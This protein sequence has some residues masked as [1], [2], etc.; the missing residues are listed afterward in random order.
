MAE[1]GNDLLDL[2][3]DGEEVKTTQI[4]APP[5]SFMPAVNA[6]S[7]KMIPFWRSN[8]QAWFLQLESQFD[9][10]GINQEQTKFNHLLGA[11]DESVFGELSDLIA[12]PPRENKFTVFKEALIS[13]LSKSDNHKIKQLLNELVLGDSRPSHLLR[14]MRTL[15]AG[16][17]SDEI[18]KSLWLQRLP[19]HIQGILACSSGSV[20]ELSVMADKIIEVSGKRE[21]YSVSAK[22]EGNAVGQL[23]K[24]IEEL[25]YQVKMLTNSRSRT[26]E[27][28]DGKRRKDLRR[29][30]SRHRESSRGHELCWYHFKFGVNASKCIQPCKFKQ[31]Q[32][33]NVVA[34]ATN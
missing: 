17:F 18:L 29:S 3:N 24:Q 23:Q 20:D 31:T 13:R 28:Y 7:V 14:E 16:K 19:S 21:V 25:T 30:K 22:P 32:G 6:V 15:G 2:A 5:Y 10:A 11:L 12:N 26:P 9:L 8:P 27:R 4:I 34:S 33:N 1:G